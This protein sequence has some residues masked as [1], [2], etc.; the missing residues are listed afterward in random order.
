MF[1][2]FQTFFYD[3]FFIVIVPGEAFRAARGVACVN[4]INRKPLLHMLK[5]FLI[6]LFSFVD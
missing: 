5:A 3:T 4:W 6:Y 1:I 2:N